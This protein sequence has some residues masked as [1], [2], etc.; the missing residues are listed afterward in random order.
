MSMLLSHSGAG[1][2]RGTYDNAVFECEG[3]PW[4][5][6]R[7]PAAGTVTNVLLGG[8]FDGATTTHDNFS[9]QLVSPDETEPYPFVLDIDALFYPPD[10]ISGG[11]SWAEK[12]PDCGEG[13]RGHAGTCSRGEF[14]AVRDR[15]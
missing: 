6:L 8:A 13:L 1:A 11:A 2:L 9:L 12:S 3:G 10:R 15:L 14:R 4:D 5:G 7:I